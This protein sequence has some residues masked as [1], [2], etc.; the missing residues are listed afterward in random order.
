MESTFFTLQD[1]MTHTKNVIYV[2]MVVI[3]IGMA[4][5]WSFLSGRDE[6]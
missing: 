4:G 1:F 3:L 2:L 5:F 6:D